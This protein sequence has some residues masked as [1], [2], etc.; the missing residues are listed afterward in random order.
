MR[1]GHILKRLDCMEFSPGPGRACMG[2]ARP[3]PKL[4]RGYLGRAPAWATASW[5]GSVGPGPLPEPGLHGR[6]QAG[7]GPSHAA[8][9]GAGPKQGPGTWAGPS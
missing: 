3:G 1:S 5:A 9:P 8:G 7:P 4:G 2:P 6:A